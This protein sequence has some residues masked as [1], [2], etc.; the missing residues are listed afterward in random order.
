[1]KDKILKPTQLDMDVHSQTGGTVEYLNVLYGSA[2]PFNN[3]NPKAPNYK[4]KCTLK[5]DTGQE[6]EVE[7]AVWNRDYGL[8]VQGTQIR[9]VDALPTK[10]QKREYE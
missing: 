5:I 9:L 1:M 6:I 7:L 10:K 4:G 2:Y 3:G 8:S